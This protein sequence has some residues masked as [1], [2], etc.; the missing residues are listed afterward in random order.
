MNYELID[1]WSA[2]AKDLPLLVIGVPKQADKALPEELAE[3]DS[4]SNGVIRRLFEGGDF[5]GARDEVAHAYLTGEGPK[6]A[7]LVGMGKAEEV[8]RGQIRRAAAVGARRAKSLGTGA[9]AFTMPTAFRSSGMALSDM[10]QAAV[11]GMGQGAWQ[12]DEL[13]TQGAGSGNKSAVPSPA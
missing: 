13:K 8:G 7:L 11:E 10:A 4:H 5:T 12:F 9:V 6:R 2:D 1:V 3:M